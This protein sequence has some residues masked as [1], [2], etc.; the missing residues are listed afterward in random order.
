MVNAT[1]EYSYTKGTCRK[2]KF[3]GKLY[4]FSNAIRQILIE[5]FKNK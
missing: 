4:T 3:A 1:K 5:Y 2:G